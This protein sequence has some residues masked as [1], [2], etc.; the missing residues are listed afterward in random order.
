MGFTTSLQLAVFMG[1]TEMVL[2]LI[3]A[4]ARFTMRN[5]FGG[6]A[7][8]AA[9]YNENVD[10]IQIQ[11]PT[12]ADVTSTNRRGDTEVVKNM[13]HSASQDA[14]ESRS[15]L[16]RE[17]CNFCSSLESKLK[18]RKLRNIIGH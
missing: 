16:R 4:G 15:R 8:H 7:L 2:L 18:G 17:Y 1:H 3:A 14:F 9:A 12:G 10:L 5:A 11:I 6:S 13:R